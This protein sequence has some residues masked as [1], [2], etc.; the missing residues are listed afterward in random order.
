MRYQDFFWDFDGTLVDTYPGM[1]RAF[2]AALIASGVNDFEIDQGAIMQAM[3]QHSFGTAL[4][5]FCAEYQLDQH[6][7]KRLYD[8]KMPA[9]FPTAPAFKGLA[10]ILTWIT[11][12]GGRNFLLTHRDHAAIERLTALDVWSTFSGA[13]TKDDDFPRKPDPASLLSLCKQYAVDRQRAVMIGD[14][15]LD[16][17]AAQRAGMAGILFDPDHRISLDSQPVVRVTQLP[18]LQAWLA[19]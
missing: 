15:N 10:D 3:R 6:R 9:E 2:S 18:E 16:I 19:E 14:R 11:D 7:V 12:Q 4:Q 13:V 17:Q 1:V 8:L 5:Q